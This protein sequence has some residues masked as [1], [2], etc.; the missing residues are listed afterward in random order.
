MCSFLDDGNFITG[1]ENDVKTVCKGLHR[2][3]QRFHVKIHRQKSSVLPLN[4]SANYD[5]IERNCWLPFAEKARVLGLT[6]ESAEHKKN[7]AEKVTKIVG[8]LSQ[9]RK[10]LFK[11]MFERVLYV[12]TYCLTLLF[13]TAPVFALP[14]N[15]AKQIERAIWRFVWTGKLEKLQI[16]MLYFPVESGGTGVADFRVI[17]KTLFLRNICEL[18]VK[19]EP[20]TAIIRQ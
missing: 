20:S 18:V 17:C 12:N 9:R 3:E 10:S 15:L 19:E 8:I 6:F 7:W 16:K 14:E 1:S 11:T 2:Y 5:D 4:K 13:Y